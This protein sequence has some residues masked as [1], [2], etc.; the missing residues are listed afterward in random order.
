MQAV[1]AATA[2][3]ESKLSSELKSFLKKNIV[4]KE[5]TD[6]LAVADAKLGGLIKEKL[7]IPVRTACHSG[8]VLVQLH[9][10][11]NGHLPRLGLLLQPAYYLDCCS[12]CSFRCSALL[13]PR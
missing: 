6:E 8:S 3:I 2:L 10:A 13:T 12:R 1:A 11:D 5:L 9:S 4:K 7:D